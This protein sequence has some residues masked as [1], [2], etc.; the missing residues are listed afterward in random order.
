MV[1]E[2]EPGRAFGL[3]LRDYRAS[4]GLSQE[5]LAEQAGLSIRAISDME[6]G[7]TSRP[8]LRSVRLLADAMSLSGS[9]R[10]QFIRT[11]RVRVDVADREA[12][13]PVGLAVVP[14]QLPAAVRHFTG[15]AAALTAMTALLDSAEDAAPAVVISAIGGTPGVG[16]TALAVHWAHQVSGRFPDGQLYVNLRGFDPSGEPTS[17]ADAIR[18]FLTAL[19]IPAGAVPADLDAQA[20]LYRS[21]LAGR[22][23]LVVLDNARDAGQVRPLLPGSPT[24]Q[25]VVTSRNPLTALVAAEGAHSLTLDLLDDREAREL[26]ARRLGSPAASDW[27]AA[28]ELIELCSRLPLALS[29]AAA[30]AATRPGMTL[31]GLAAELREARGRLDALEIPDGR[32]ATAAGSGVRAVFGWSYL[33]LSQP[34]A[35]MFRLVGIHPGPDV[36]AAAAASLAACSPEQARQMLAELTTAQ[37]LTENSPGRFTFHDL[38]RVYAAEQGRSSDSATDRRTALHRVLDYYLH[39]AHSA[40]LLLYPFSNPITLAAPLPGVEPEQP[41]DYGHALRWF[42]REHAVLLAVT[43]LAASEGFDVHAWQLPSSLEDFLDR[44]G[45]WRELDAVQVTALAAADRIGDLTGQAHAHLS[46]GRVRSALG[47]SQDAR[48]HML[49]A[50]RLYRQLGDLAG[51]A[52]VHR[53]LSSRAARQ[54]HYRRALAHAR[55][56]LELCVAGDDAAGQAMAL[57]NI[58]WDQILLGDYPQALD[59]CQR[60]LAIHTGLGN[61]T[62]MASTT[63]SIGCAYHHLGQYDLAIACYQEALEIFER[64]GDRYSQAIVLGNLGDTHHATGCDD[65][66]RD[67]W[68]RALAILGELGHSDAGEVRSKLKDLAE[69]S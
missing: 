54:G 33:T 40:S 14:R 28:G 1:V 65:H 8:F 15:R 68:C 29:I 7:R 6:R 46:L 3:L 31:G 23:M 44:C 43:H 38:L 37:L 34:A 41:G 36:S 4:A 11:S 51:Q 19:R 53:N 49:R 17:P 26:L 55:K 27:Q 48:F 25:V 18:G 64:L 39:T 57:N 2:A 10:E 9:M 5:E 45:H 42:E 52:S 35:R 21:L 13:P 58:G 20:A 62:G 56:T 16:K 66:A 24:C 69:V 30:S 67:A 61:L 60:A 47:N 32:D 12:G 50:L 63:D 22:K 59:G